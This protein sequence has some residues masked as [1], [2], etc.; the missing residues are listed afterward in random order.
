MNKDKLEYYLIWDFFE[1]ESAL[2]YPW[3]II[4]IYPNKKIKEQLIFMKDFIK[5]RSQ[6][7]HIFI[8]GPFI[9]GENE[10]RKIVSEFKDL[11]YLEKEGKIVI[12][13]VP[14]LIFNKI[15]TLVEL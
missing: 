11:L 9:G 10:N 2:F 5:T 1:G 14:Y 15:E 4:S 12:W 13:K 3:T 8:E 6:T 7:D